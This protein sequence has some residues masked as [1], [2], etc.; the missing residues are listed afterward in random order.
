MRVSLLMHQKTVPRRR[1]DG[2]L[3]L[4][5]KSTAPRHSHHL[6]LPSRILTTA[7]K[8]SEEERRDAVMGRDGI[9]LNFLILAR[10]S[11]GIIV[12]AASALANSTCLRTIF[13]GL[14]A[15]FA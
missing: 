8:N 11:D 9:G 13:A 12:V 3:P 5:S 6:E 14:D 1:G 10:R 2:S 15:L 4:L 7:I